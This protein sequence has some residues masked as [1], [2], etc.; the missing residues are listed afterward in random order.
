MLAGAEHGRAGALRVV[1]F[2]GVS[3]TKFRV[4]MA[5]RRRARREQERQAKVWE[6]V[7][8][9]RRGHKANAGRKVVN[10]ILKERR[11]LRKARDTADSTLKRRNSIKTKKKAPFAD[12]N[13]RN[14]KISTPDA[15]EKTNTKS[16]SILP[17]LCRTPS[18]SKAQLAGT[19]RGRDLYLSSPGNRINYKQIGWDRFFRQRRRSK[20]S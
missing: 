17:K 20:K 14:Q 18:A 9:T 6:A 8:S 12:E 11:L 10:D 7:Q 13:V 5:A 3:E 16:K 4:R 2:V 1:L 19:A 15:S